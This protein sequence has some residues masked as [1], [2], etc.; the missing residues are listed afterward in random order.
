[1]SSSST[2]K[3]VKKAFESNLLQATI[4]LNGLTDTKKQFQI[5]KTRKKWYYIQQSVRNFSQSEF[6]LIR[7]TNCVSEYYMLS[8]S[9]S[10]YDHLTLTKCGNLVNLLYIP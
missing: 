9:Q 5:K 2:Q 3:N 8:V 7:T 1:M 4:K 10:L 6:Y